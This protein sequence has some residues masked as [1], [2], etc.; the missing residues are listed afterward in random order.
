[1][2]D[3]KRNVLI[4]ARLNNAESGPTSLYLWTGGK[5]DAVAVPGQEMPGGGQFR[6]ITLVHYGVSP[7]N[8]LGQ[9]AFIARL[10]DGATA[11]YTGWT[12]TGS[13][14]SS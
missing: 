11:A 9:H 14:P 10:A 1:M 12:A 13:C 8:R 4:A 5:L 7:T 2:N 3:A 6:E